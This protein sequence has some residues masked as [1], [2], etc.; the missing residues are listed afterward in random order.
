[1]K[2]L[3]R[4]F[5]FTLLA[6][7]LSTFLVWFRRIGGIEWAIVVVILGRFYFDAN[8]VEKGLP[9]T[10]LLDFVLKFFGKG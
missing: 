9:G 1:M 4:K 3:G 10:G 8:R 6:L 2:F 7:S 5:L